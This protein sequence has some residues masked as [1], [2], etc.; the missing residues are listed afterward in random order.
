MFSNVISLLSIRHIWI[1]HYT[2]SKTNISYCFA[3]KEQLLY[4]QDASISGK[5]HVSYYFDVVDIRCRFLSWI[6]ISRR[7][8][9]YLQGQALHEEKVQAGVSTGV[10]Y[11]RYV[12]MLEGWS[13]G[14]WTATSSKRR[15]AWYDSF[16]RA[17]VAIEFNL[18]PHV[19]PYLPFSNIL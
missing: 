18:T 3:S 10:H 16:V 19:F 7:S 2:R 5:I 8:V 6:K 13:V 14:K 11:M 15:L 9:L 4:S 12:R 17:C 1:Q